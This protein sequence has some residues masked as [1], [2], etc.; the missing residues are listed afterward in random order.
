MR[1]GPLVDQDGFI[2]VVSK[3]YRNKYVQ[4]SQGRG[5]PLAVSNG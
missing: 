3:N 5:S 1:P 4:R 2:Q